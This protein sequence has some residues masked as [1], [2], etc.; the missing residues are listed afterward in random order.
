MPFLNSDFGNAVLT[1]SNELLYK[2]PSKLFGGLIQLS[3]EF[4]QDINT[5]INKTA[6]YFNFM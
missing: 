4:L 5:A 6:R 2:K 1:E 3:L